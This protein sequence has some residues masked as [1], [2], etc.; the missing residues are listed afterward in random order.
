MD[1]ISGLITISLNHLL[2]P[3]HEFPEI[4]TQYRQISLPISTVVL[5]IFPFVKD[6]LLLI[7]GISPKSRKPRTQQ[8]KSSNAHIKSIM[9][10]PT[11]STVDI[12]FSGKC[13]SQV[14]YLAHLANPVG[15]LTPLTFGSSFPNVLIL[16]CIT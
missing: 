10:N 5:I 7:P 15:A 11:Q 8:I 4:E 16:Q 6:L 13:L 14:S 2:Y 1:A 3:N 9:S 12:L